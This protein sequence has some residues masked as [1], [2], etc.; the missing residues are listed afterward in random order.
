MLL[1]AVII[2]LVAGLMGTTVGTGIEPV[3][4]TSMEIA[5]Q[6]DIDQQLSALAANLSTNESGDVSTTSNRSTESA[7]PITTENKV[8]SSGSTEMDVSAVEMAV[9]DEINRRRTANGLEKLEYRS[10]LAEVARYHSRDMAQEEYFAHDSPDGESLG[11]RYR[12]FGIECAGGENVAYTYWK[13]N[14]RTE[15]GLQYYDTKQQLAVGLVNGW[16]NSTGHRENILRER[17]Q[18]EGIGIYLTEVDGQTRVYATQN[19]C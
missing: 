13:E 4:Q 12:Q 15:E 5:K 6:A 3:D 9:H 1:I 16:M 8:T 2:V 18:S 19:F 14:V 10:S 17:F 7:Q 11:D